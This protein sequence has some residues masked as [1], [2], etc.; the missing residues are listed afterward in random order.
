MGNHKKIKCDDCKEF[1]S[2]G[3]VHPSRDTDWN[4]ERKQWL[5]EFMND[6]IGCRVRM[7]GEYNQFEQWGELGRENEY[8]EVEY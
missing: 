7:V 4:E 1:L 3:K 5:L 6:H 2:L 8:T